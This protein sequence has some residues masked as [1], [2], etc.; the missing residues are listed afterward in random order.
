MAE[1]IR[2]EDIP[3]SIDAIASRGFV[4]KLGRRSFIIYKPEFDDGQYRL[5]CLVGDR[6]GESLHAKAAEPLKAEAERW[7]PTIADSG[8]IQPAVDDATLHSQAETIVPA[9]ILVV[10]DNADMR[11]YLRHLLSGRYIVLT[12]ANGAEALQAIARQTPDLVALVRRR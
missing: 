3:S 8:A 12:V 7:L 10:D 9:R 6:D 2:W 5:L 4:G 1:R 11:D